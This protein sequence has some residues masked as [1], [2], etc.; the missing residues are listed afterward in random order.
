MEETQSVQQDTLP[1][2]ID[3]LL[4]GNGGEA[5]LLDQ[6]P[7]EGI[8]EQPDGTPEE[9]SDDLADD[10]NPAEGSEGD[11]DEGEEEAEVDPDND[12]EDLDLEEGADQEE[13]EEP[14]EDDATDEPFLSKE[15]L[16]KHQKRIDADPSLKAVYK[17]M[18]ADYTRK[19]QEVQTTGREYERAYGELQQFE[20]TLKDVAE[21]GGRELFLVKA[22][23]DNPEAFQRAFDQAAELLEDPE[24]R[25]KYE[26]ER[27]VDEREKRV[28]QQ[29]GEKQ[30]EVLK[31]R[32]Q[33][34][35]ALSERVAEKLGIGDEEGL[36]IAKRFVAERIRYNREQTGQAQ[37][38][39]AEVRE[40][41]NDAAKR[42]LGVRQRAE[43]EAERKLRLQRQKDAKASALNSKKRAAPR[44]RRVATE[45]GAREQP[46]DGFRQ[47]L[48]QT[49]SLLD[50]GDKLDT[51]IDQ[52]LG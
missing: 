22:A 52:R 23:L 45:V 46:G 8:D 7:E 49:R 25:K 28:A 10:D 32:V 21:G 12:D 1:G 9:Q 3:R 6:S 20:D 4:G 33:Q 48:A 40:A 11:E 35:H 18:Q 29:E 13:D 24:A 38:S 19:M 39:D 37:I 50:G 16:K 27:E 5:G 30:Q 34:I 43:K 14:T 15:T 44:S 51:L 31:Q 2:T 36:D 26:R 47:P 41:V 17:S 42:I